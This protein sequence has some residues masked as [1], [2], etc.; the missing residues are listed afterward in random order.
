MVGLNGRVECKDE[1]EGLN[2]RIEWKD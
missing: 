1:M 2:G